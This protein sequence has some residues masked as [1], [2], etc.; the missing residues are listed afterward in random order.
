MLSAVIQMLEGIQQSFICFS[1]FIQ[2]KLIIVE[3]HPKTLYQG[4]LSVMKDLHSIGIYFCVKSLDN[5][6]HIIFC[7]T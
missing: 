3:K 2:I 4:A 7:I 6:S 5:V 1:Y